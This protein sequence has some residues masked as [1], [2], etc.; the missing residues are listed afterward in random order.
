MEVDDNINKFKSAVPLSIEKLEDIYRQLPF[1]KKEAINYALIPSWE[2]EELKN[3]PR[4]KFRVQNIDRVYL[5][6]YYRENGNT[7]YNFCARFTSKEFPQQPLYMKYNGETENY[8]DNPYENTVGDIYVTANPQIFFEMLLDTPNIEEFD[9]YN[10]E[11]LMG[12]DNIQITRPK[13]NPLKSLIP[14]FSDNKDLEENILNIIRGSGIEILP[15]EEKDVYDIKSITL[16]HFDRLYFIH[17]NDKNFELIG[18]VRSSYRHKNQAPLY[19]KVKRNS[20]RLLETSTIFVTANPQSF[21]NHIIYS[22]KPAHIYELNYNLDDIKD[23]LREDGIPINVSSFKSTVL[24]KMNPK[25]ILRSNMGSFFL[26]ELEEYDIHYNLKDEKIMSMIKKQQQFIKTWPININHYTVNRVYHIHL[27]EYKLDNHWDYYEFWG[28]LKPS[29][30]Y[31]CEKNIPPFYVILRAKFNIDNENIRGSINVFD[32]PQRFLDYISISHSYN[33]IIPNKENIINEIWYSM[34][35]DSISVSLPS[36]SRFKSLQSRITKLNDIVRL[37][38]VLYNQKTFHKIISPWEK[39]NFRDIPNININPQTV[40]CVYYH[41]HITEIEKGREYHIFLGRLAGNYHHKDNLPIYVKLVARKLFS[42]VSAAVYG[43][44]FITA[45]PQSF[46]NSINS[47]YES[48]RYNLDSIIAS[49]REDDNNISIQD[50]S[51]NIFTSLVPTIELPCQ[52]K[53]LIKIKNDINNFYKNVALADKETTNLDNLFIYPENI[54]YIYYSKYIPM[55]E[56]N[57]CQYELLAKLLPN[58]YHNKDGC[59]L[60]VHILAIKKH[61]NGDNLEQ[62]TLTRKKFTGLIYA[63]TMPEIFL[64]TISKKMYNFPEIK[65]RIKMD[66]GAS[67]EKKHY[68]KYFDE[69]KLN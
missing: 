43:W 67:K 62:E 5:F 38:Y 48:N 32:D 50:P 36:I 54:H 7:I 6:L 45:N 41:N 8:C 27:Q 19:I 57:D 2:R 30:Y 20:E 42:N 12:E 40:N 21:L 11:V 47:S 55:T 64:N 58:Y 33:Y 51:Q 13:L 34:K 4:L 18:R 59:P 31:L 23:S 60:Y 9:I 14:S 56:R 66:F 3:R 63:T 28:R 29:S 10:A 61:N 15:W 25:D 24:R 1:L 35:N 44:I 68:L 46:I 52:D 49:I 39:Q 53:G 69:K 26:E 17:E 37:H 22:I 65:Q 16:Q